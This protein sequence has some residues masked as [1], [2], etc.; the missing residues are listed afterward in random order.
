M[1]D[2][3]IIGGG[4]IGLSIARELHRSGAGK[5]TVLDKGVCGGG[6]SWAAAGMLSPDVHGVEHDSFY[7]LCAA[8][9]AMFPALAAELN[10]ETDVDIELEQTGTLEVAVGDKQGSQLLAKCR[11][12]AAAGITA[13]TLSLEDLLK[14]E[15]E[16]SSLITIGAFYPNDWQVENRKLLAALRR[17]AELNGIEIRENIE[18][19]NVIVYDGR[20]NGVGTAAG[21]VSA[22]HTIIATGA[23]TSLIKLGS[24]EMP[25]DVK[26]IR[27]QIVE[28]QGRPGEIAH[29]IWSDHGY[30]VPRR[31]GRILAG[32]TSEDV[33]FDHSVT[34]EARDELISMATQIAPVIG[35]LPVTAHWSG[36]RP[37]AA[38]GL[39]VIG[40]VAGIDGLTVASGHYRNGILLAPITARLVADRILNNEA[41]LDLAA[42]RPDRFRSA[43]AI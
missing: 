42:F 1:S 23:W 4:V 7:E 39:P 24:S 30:I 11:A 12:Q 3:L 33:G 36:L 18:V 17:Y 10:E 9:E 13:E 28:F 25:F 41:T 15:P 2:V 40:P 16:L 8:S 6:A 14:R 35:T 38:D 34:D 32:S 19:T 5:I 22:E 29:V 26:P 21:R 20:A 27:G 31:D 37:F 43:A